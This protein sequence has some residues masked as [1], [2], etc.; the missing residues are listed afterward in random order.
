MSIAKEKYSA[1]IQKNYVPVFFRN[2]FLDIV[3]DS[4]W[5]VVLYEV[6]DEIK[7]AYV[8]M[9]KQKLGI[10]YIVQPQLCPYTGP[11]FFDSGTINISY[12]KFLEKLPKHQLIIQDYFFGIPELK[13]FRNTQYKKHTYI[14]EANTD[15]QLLWEKQSSTHRRIIRKAKKELKY[16]EEE[17]IDV[18]LEFVD[19]TFKKRNKTVPNDP[20]IFRKLDEVLLLNNQRK[21]VK[22]I[23]E[24]NDI[25]AMCYFM[26]DEKWTYNFAN[27]VV[28]D[29]RH[30]GMN[31]IIWNEIESSL[32]EGR[33]FDF[34]G[35]M[36]SGIDEFF[37]RF[38]G[39]QVKY[40]S[41][42]KTSNKLIDLLVKL[43]ISKDKL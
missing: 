36:I 17:H 8:F 3:C 37:K 43:K 16:E 15:S 18:F 14:I 41:R 6:E 35:S 31:L 11:I 19:S 32:K 34:E 39:R 38:K 29:Y 21:I 33:S 7:A 28:E 42:V 30:Y 9:K 23:N 5:D 13:G 10:N 26:K 12:S 22:C 27:S 1:F 24:K 40:A 20:T 4:P 25:V 2:H